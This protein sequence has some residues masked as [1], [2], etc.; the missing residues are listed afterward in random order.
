MTVSTFIRGWVLPSASVCLAACVLVTPGRAQETESSTAKS[1]PRPITYWVQQLGHPHYLRREMASK[2][3]TEAGPDVIEHLVA[4]VGSGDLEV[5]ERAVRVITQIALSGP[6]MNDGGAWDQLNQMASSG[7]GRQ[8]SVARSALGEVRKHRARQ[9]RE[10]L[11]AAGIFVGIDEFVISAISRPML[12]VQIDDQWNRDVESLQWL[13]WLDDVENARLKASAVTPEVVRAITDVPGLRTLAIVDAKVTDETLQPLTEM[14]R[15]HS[16]EFRYV[17]LT[18]AQG[19]LIASM[20]IRVSLNL[21]GTGI[22]KEKVDSM[23]AQLPGLQ[24]DHRQGGFLGVTCIDNLD[25]CE[26]SGVVNG[27]AAEVAGIIKGDIIIRIDDTPIT[28]FRDLQQAINQHLPGD[29]VEVKYRRGD[30]IESV[31]LRLGRLEES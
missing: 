6:P 8:A 16:L 23:K 9:A 20:P 7:V 24:I 14:S 13:R 12:I 28:K 25:V 1:S 18:D 5:V 15:L 30:N 26:I 4:V 27:G 10:A 11:E 2:K 29:E 3:L 21:M 19:D 17:P 31:T 22:S